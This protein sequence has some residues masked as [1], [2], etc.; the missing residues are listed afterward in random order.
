[1]LASGFSQTQKKDIAGTSL[2]FPIIMQKVLGKGHIA[3]TVVG[4]S[5]IKSIVKS[6]IILHKN[7]LACK[8]TRKPKNIGKIMSDLSDQTLSHS[9]CVSGFLTNKS[10]LL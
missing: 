1:M 9:E 5:T 4:K 8:C 3:G 6:P 7:Q 2:N 10:S